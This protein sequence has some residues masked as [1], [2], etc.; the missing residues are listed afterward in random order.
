LPELSKKL[1]L[2]I[3]AVSVTGITLLVYWTYNIA[4]S[5]EI[6]G[7]FLLWV[8]LAIIAE[9]TPVALPQGGFVTLG[10]PIIYASLLI[11]GPGIS[12]WVAIVCNTIMEGKQR[13]RKFWYAIPFDNAQLVL[14]VSAAWIVYQYMG[15]TPITTS[16]IGHILPIISSALVYFLTNTW[17]VNI[18]LALQKKTPV[19]EMWVVNFKWIIPNYLAQTPIG[20]L[21]AVAYKQI[22]WWAVLF[23]CFP[24]FIAY[25][26]YKLYADLRKQHL[27]TIHALAAAIE[28]RDAYTE[29][30][31]MR[32]SE[33]AVATARELK[34]PINEVEVIHYAA[35]LHDIG[36]IGINDQTL[37]KP[38]ELNKEEWA[39]VRKHPKIG[40]DIIGKIDSLKKAS[41]LVYYHHERY[42]GQGYPEKLKGEDIPIGARI[43]AVIDAYDAMTSKRPYRSAYSDEKAMEELK[44]NAGTQFDKKVVK[45]FLK[46]LK[47][48]QNVT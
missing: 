18:A 13:G 16:S 4:F 25:Y 20:Y 8:V 12:S 35:I 19:L 24:L 1:W 9:L 21:M 37:N 40:A 2:Y 32:M 15:G 39:E 22:S 23:L 38:G 30:H 14:S 27:S 28:A 43:L 6:V 48:S 5:W 7:G 44:K 29:N 41:Q 36:K 3:I 33:L 26:A 47:S 10:F 42:N 11:Y 31:S 45:A 17:L 34:F 46:V